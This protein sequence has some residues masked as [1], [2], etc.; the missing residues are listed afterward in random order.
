MG[1]SRLLEVGFGVGGTAAL[2][3]LAPAGGWW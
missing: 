3:M 2:I 1:F